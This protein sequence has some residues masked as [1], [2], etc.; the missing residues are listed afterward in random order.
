LLDVPRHD[1]VTDLRPARHG[2]PLPRSAARRPR[3][4]LGRA[5][6]SFGPAGRIAATLLLLAPVWWF[7]TTNT[8]GV[9][10]LPVWVLFVLPKALRDIWLGG[11][12]HG[13]RLD[14]FRRRSR[15]GERTDAIGDRAGPTRW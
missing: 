15:G 10:A 11:R 1:D 3:T 13:H 8:L 5:V 6:A 7:V 14:G 9:V 2:A 12:G 4:R